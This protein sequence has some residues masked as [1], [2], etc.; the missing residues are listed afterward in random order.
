MATKRQPTSKRVVWSEPGYKDGGEFRLTWGRI[1]AIVGVLAALV[2][3]VPTFWAL[4]DH[5]MNRAEIQTAL[6]AHADHDAG[7]QAW[8]QYGFAANRLEYLNDK[9]DECATKRITQMKLPPVDIAICA[10]YEAKQLAK[11]K[12]ADE[13]KAKAMETTKEKQ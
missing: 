10:R 5:Y 6:K 2:G 8:N 9:Q 12:E 11:L 7:A 1:A 3:A 13:L 4:S